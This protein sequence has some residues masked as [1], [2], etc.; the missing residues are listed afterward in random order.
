MRIGSDYPGVFFDGVV[1]P[2]CDLRQE[3]TISR[4]NSSTARAA[5]VSPCATDRR[6]EGA[7]SSWQ[8][9]QVTPRPGSYRW[10]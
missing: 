7:Q 6:L 10:P 2:T 8:T 5:S 1:L 4:S 9:S 3:G